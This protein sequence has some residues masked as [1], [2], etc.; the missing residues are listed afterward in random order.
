MKLLFTR[1]LCVALTYM[2]TNI[3]FKGAFSKNSQVKYY[4]V[5]S[6]LHYVE[7]VFTS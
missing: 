1:Q 6:S 3:K 2:V 4:G 7:N 5:A